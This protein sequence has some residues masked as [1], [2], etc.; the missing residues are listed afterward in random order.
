MMWRGA[1]AKVLARRGQAD[2]AQALAREGVAII[3]QTDYIL[4]H[5]DALTDL[6]EVLRLGD[7]A[8]EAAAAANEARLLYEQKGNIIAA[9]HLQSMLE[10]LRPPR[11]AAR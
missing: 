11:A 10:E 9:R 7:Q 4:Y 3:R 2:E 6:A 8:S 1:R 5:A